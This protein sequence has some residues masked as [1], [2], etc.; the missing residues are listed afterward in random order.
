MGYKKHHIECRDKILLC[1]LY[2]C[3]H[4]SKRK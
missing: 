3:R 1:S 4:L 2:L